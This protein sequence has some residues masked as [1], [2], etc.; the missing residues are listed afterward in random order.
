MRP[1]EIPVA[2]P[3][4]STLGAA[5][6]IRLDEAAIS[7]LADGLALTSLLVTVALAESV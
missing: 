6:R 2:T 4:A 5:Q 1:D 7:L 3:E